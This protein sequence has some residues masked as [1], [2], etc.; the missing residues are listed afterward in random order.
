MKRKRDNLTYTT[1]SA[2]RIRLFSSIGGLGRCSIRYK[3]PLHTK[4]CLGTRQQLNKLSN[5]VCDKTLFM[6][7]LTSTDNDVTSKIFLFQEKRYICRQTLPFAYIAD[8]NSCQQSHL[9]FKIACMVEK[10]S[11][12]FELN[13]QLVQ[14]IGMHVYTDMHALSVNETKCRQTHKR[15]NRYAKT[16]VNDALTFSVVYH[17]KWKKTEIN[18][19]KTQTTL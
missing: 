18:S 6:S 13:L 16:L 10:S 15:I 7:N 1:S 3:L 11:M 9:A 19:K 2:I 12:G 4:E 14:Y 5:W 17:L 8:Q